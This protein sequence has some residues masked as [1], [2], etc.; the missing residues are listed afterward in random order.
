VKISGFTIARDAVRFDYPLAESLRSLLP[1]VDELVVAVGDCD[2]GTW[3][4]VQ[5]IGDPKIRAFRTVW[6]TGQGEN[7]LSH[8]TNKALDRCSGDWAVYLQADEVLHEDDLTVLRR[9]LERH[10]R[11]R[12]EGLS[13]RYL[14]FYGSYG[15]VQDNPMWFYRRAV[16]AVRTGA[17]VRSV[18]DACGFFVIGPHGSRRLQRANSR[19]RVFHYGW[20]RPPEVMARKQVNLMRLVDGPSVAEP[21]E[22]GRLA[23]R[24]Y[25]GRGH[26]RHFRGKHPAVMGERIG[27]CNWSFDP[28]IEEQPPDWLR[29]ARVY[30]QW[31]RGD[32][33]ARVGRE[34]ANRWRAV[35]GRRAGARDGAE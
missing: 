9:D 20:V 21:A 35:V 32:L 4:L 16:R 2:D 33:R 10:H 1:L 5:G 28:R 22:A 23:A 34:L 26:L 7:V 19:A 30:L 13:L 14:H 18:G 6:D 8:E 15:T 27:R 11:G 25:D 24:I 3:E 17:G 31:W 29:L 12:I